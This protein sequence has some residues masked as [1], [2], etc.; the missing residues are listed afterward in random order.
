MKTAVINFLASF[1]KNEVWQ[2]VC[3]DEFVCGIIFGIGVYLI[4]VLLVHLVFILCRRR[5]KCSVLVISSENGDIR[6]SLKAVTGFLISKLAVFNQVKINKVMIFNKRNG[7]ALEL[8]GRFIP[9]ESGAPD[10]FDRIV[11][12]VKVQ[13]Q[14][15]FG[16][17]NIAKVDLVIS[18]SVTDEDSDSANAD[19]VQNGTVDLM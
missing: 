17:T 19:T 11:A 18:E 13:M 3:H 8:R 6:V 5:K 14:E 2:S 7:Y 16:I 10:L 9:G 15:T 1:S 12:A 4:L